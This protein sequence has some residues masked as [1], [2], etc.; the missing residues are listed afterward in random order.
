[1][2]LD[3]KRSGIA[4]QVA[5]DSDTVSQIGEVRVEA[6]PPR[7][8]KGLDLLWFASDLLRV[9]ICDSAARRRPLKVRIELDPIRRIYVEAL[10]L[11]PQPLALCQRRH[12]LQA[13]A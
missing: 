2:D 13:V 1:A 4:K 10:H 7:V 9:A 6:I 5:R 11:P 8:S 3:K 12:H